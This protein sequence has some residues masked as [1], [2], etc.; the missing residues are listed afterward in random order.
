MANSVDNATNDTSTTGLLTSL[1]T[2]VDLIKGIFTPSTPLPPISK[3]EFKVGME[4]RSGLS[5]MDIASEII[6][7][8][9]RLG[10]PIS[11]L[12]SGGKNLAIAMEAVRVD[13]VMKYIME[14]AKIEV[15]IPENQILVKVDGI[16]SGGDA[17][18]GIGVNSFPIIGVAKGEGI[19]R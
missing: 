17:V 5:P 8:Q 1:K 18:Q 2:L 16:T 12:P 15:I 11:P 7:K 6:D 3:V 19:I 9:A 4:F 10:I 14:N 13:T